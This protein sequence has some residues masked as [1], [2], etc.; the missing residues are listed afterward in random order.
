MLRWQI[1]LFQFDYEIVYRA[2]EFN[3]VPDVVARMYRLDRNKEGCCTMGWR[4]LKSEAAPNIQRQNKAPLNEINP[5]P[6]ERFTQVYIDIIG[7]LS[8]SNGY[9]YLLMII[10]R[11]SRFIQAMPF[12]GIIAEEC[13]SAFVHGSVSLF[14]SPM[15]N[16]TYVY[17]DRGAQFTSALWRDL[18]QFLGAQLH[19]STAYH[20]QTQGMVERFN[21]ALKTALKCAEAPT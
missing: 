2:G 3:T 18:A 17:C 4:I 5:P 11:Y 6:S 13:S 8:P 21:K 20:P 7:P 1:E 10:D 19:H 16:C 9:S 12:L 14:G 15:H